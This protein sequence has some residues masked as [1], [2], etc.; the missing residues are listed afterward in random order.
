MVRRV[1]YIGVARLDSEMSAPQTKFSVVGKRT[2]ASVSHLG[3]RNKV[4]DEMRSSPRTWIKSKGTKEAGRPFCLILN[5]P[6][7]TPEERLR[8][9]ACIPF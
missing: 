3:A 8:S 4:G 7:K 5:N 9:E 1:Y 2:V 6:M